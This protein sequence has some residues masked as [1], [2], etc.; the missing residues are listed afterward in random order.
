MKKLL[1]GMMLLV[2]CAACGSS[3]GVDAG[4]GIP[5]ASLQGPLA[6]DAGLVLESTQLSGG[7]TPGDN[8]SLSI[9]SGC[10]GGLSDLE[11]SLS[12]FARDHSK[13]KAG[14]ITVE[15]RSS[16]TAGNV[17]ANVEYQDFRGTGSISYSAKSGT[18]TMDTL[19][20]DQLSNNAGHFEAVMDMRDGGTTQLSG[21]FDGRSRCQ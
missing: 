16:G 19:D 2:T 10:G 1:V 17:F 12:L 20:F 3:S 21:S 8:L 5:R 18:V 11:V 13:L 15:A 14:A 7:A 4:P 9:Q 6:F